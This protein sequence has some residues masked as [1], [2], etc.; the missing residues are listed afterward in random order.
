MAVSQDLPA[1]RLVRTPSERASLDA[2]REVSGEVNGQ[3]ERHSV[4]Q[5]FIAEKLGQDRGLEIDRELLVC[6]AFLHDAGLFPGASTG[7]VYT[8]DGRLLAQRVLA[9]FAWPPARMA[10]CLDAI[11]QHHALRSRWDWGVEVEL[12]RLSDLV[13][14]VP[15]LVRFGIPRE[16]LRELFVELPRRGFYRHIW[17]QFVRGLRERP[18]TVPGMFRPPSRPTDPQSLAQPR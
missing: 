11:E 12:M 8:Q 3:M 6:V 9:P 15:R 17:S 18:A 4:R 5:F 16:W 2:L 14:V 1:D 13:D 7:G 10:L